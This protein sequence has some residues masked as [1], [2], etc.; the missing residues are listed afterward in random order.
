VPHEYEDHIELTL[1]ATPEQVWDA[2]ATGPGLDAWFMGRTEVEPREGG[3]V[4]TDMGGVVEEFEV[5]AWEPQKRFAFRTRAQEDGSFVALE[6]LIEGREKG[7]T[8]LRCVA[9]GFIGADDW[10]AEYDALTKGGAMYL[11]TLTQYLAHFAHRT[12]TAINAAHPLAGD[13]EH[14]WTVLRRDLGATGTLAEGDQVRLTPTGLPPLEGVVDYATPEFL[15]VR[16][17]DGLYRFF[18]G[19]HGIVAVN[20]HIFAGGVDR[21]ETQQAWQAWLTRLFA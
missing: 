16:T 7:S 9:S 21:Q 8:V 4:R 2:I 3:A 15:G 5:T 17:S 13:P 12:A 6:W 19:G 18:A 10:E 20:H 14:A 1:D 11:H